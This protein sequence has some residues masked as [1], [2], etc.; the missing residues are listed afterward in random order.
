MLKIII[1]V[2]LSI[3]CLL[4]LFTVRIVL[5]SNRSKVEIIWGTV[6]CISGIFLWMIYIFAVI[7]PVLASILEIQIISFLSMMYLL[8]YADY[9]MFRVCDFISSIVAGYLLVF[10][11]SIFLLV[12]IVIATSLNAI[13]VLIGITIFTIVIGFT[14]A[15]LFKLFESPALRIALT[16]I[17]YLLSILGLALSFA[18]TVDPSNYLSL[19]AF[20]ESLQNSF[21][22]PKDSNYIWIHIIQFFTSRM[23]DFTMFGVIVHILSNLIDFAKRS[24]L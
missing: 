8:V 10:T 24:K 23:I 22:L 17:I 1:V 2:F 16:L 18:V 20:Y 15:I 14:Y 7:Y 11:I 3:M 21:V 13:F 4:F 12:C 6:A 5:R 9:L 19:A